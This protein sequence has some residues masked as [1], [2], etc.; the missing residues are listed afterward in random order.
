M[1]PEF[2][3]PPMN[4]PFVKIFCESKPGQQEMIYSQSISQKKE[5]SL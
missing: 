5:S 2:L 4:K 3:Y 1:L